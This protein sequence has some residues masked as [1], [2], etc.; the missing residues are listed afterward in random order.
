VLDFNI[1]SSSGTPDDLKNNL[2]K[3]LNE[4]AVKYKIELIETD[5]AQ[6][7]RE[8]ILALYAKMGEQV[9]ILVDEYDMPLVSYLDNIAKADAN[10]AVLREFYKIL[11]SLGN[12]IKFVLITGVS[13][14]SKMSILSG[15]NNVTDITLKSVHNDIVGLTQED[16]ETCF[17]PY[18]AEVVYKME[19]P[20]E[21]LLE[22]M[23][24][25]YGGYSW[26][27]KQHLYNPLSILKLFENVQF[28]NYWYDTA[29]PQFLIDMIKKQKMLP[30][31]LENI[32]LSELELKDSD[33]D[34]VRLESLLLQTGFLTVKHVQTMRSGNGQLYELDLPNN[35]VRLSVTQNLWSLMEKD[36]R[37]TAVRRMQFSFSLPYSL[38]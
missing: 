14:F 16:I 17:E 15:F 21:E 18:M 30:I 5:Y 1:I 27:G 6:R 2:I 32:R 7:F 31:D 34:N 13:R 19:M 24:F 3:S 20:R 26:T 22:L 10:C 37:K 8:L 36:R 38:V 28:L 33:L 4:C 25:W 35:E 9:V 11:K 12:E 29:T 23:R